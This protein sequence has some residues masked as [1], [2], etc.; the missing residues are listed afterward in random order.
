MACN[1]EQQQILN[2]ILSSSAS[3]VLVQGKAG[4]GKSYLIREL[5]AQTHCTILVP[6]NMAKSVYPQAVTMHSF[7]WGEF[8]DLEEGYQNPD[9]YRYVRMPERSRLKILSL[10]F[11]VIDE[12]SMVRSDMFEMMN[13]IC[14]VVR[15]DSRPFGGIKVIM[16][17]DVFQLPPIVTEKETFDYLKDKYGGIFFFN[18]HIIH[19]NLHNIEFLE[20]KKSVRQQ[21]DPIYERILDTFRKRNDVET[22]IDL[23]EHLNN[24]VM[25]SDRIPSNIVTIATTNA[26]VARVNDKE[27]AKIPGTIKQCTAEFLIQKKDHS[28]YLT[29]YG[30]D[31][32]SYDHKDYYP[33]EVPSQFSPILKYKVGSRVLFTSSQKRAGYINGDFG[34]VVGNNNGT[35][36]VRNE[37]TGERCEVGSLAV[38]RYKML[39]DP[40][41]RDLSRQTPYIQRTTQYPLKSA[42]AFTVHKSQGQ[43][44]DRIIIDLESHIFASGQ[45]YVALS[46][47]KSLDGL[48][49]TRPISLSDF[50]VDPSVLDF[51]SIM[52]GEPVPNK[53]QSKAPLT[54]QSREFLNTVRTSNVDTPV[55]PVISNLIKSYN[56]IYQVKNYK[57]SFLELLKILEVLM[58]TFD[59]GAYNTGISTIRATY[60]GEVDQNK[61]DKTLEYLKR[62]YSSVINTPPKTLIVDGLHEF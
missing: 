19:N 41:K 13:K 22:T 44:Y 17:G 27:L 12:I 48:Y 21:N 33:V 59:T 53:T 45:L 18:S 35:I 26:E 9:K 37:R 28:S 54:E 58:S 47:V 49:L 30:E 55:N 29:F 32:S 61:C 60:P 16:V 62:L 51:M 4:S 11:L 39:Y 3:F 34:T 31:D 46:R 56:S 50:I 10:R 36:F 25:S 38:R 2:R 52:H 5:W 15:N 42:Y 7:F 57:Y 1:P 6:T 40:H 8:D 43:T 20:L 14:Q 24:R 23:L